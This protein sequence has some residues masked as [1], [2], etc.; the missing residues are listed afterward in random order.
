MG[1]EI[2]LQLEFIP[3][4]HFLIIKRFEVRRESVPNRFFCGH[5][6]QASCNYL[7]QARPKNHPRG[8]AHKCSE[9]ILTVCQKKS[10]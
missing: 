2:R 6:G 7:F 10:S 9:L 3:I 5:N 8:A 1:M 4:P